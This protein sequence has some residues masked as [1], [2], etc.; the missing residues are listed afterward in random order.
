MRIF[1]VVGAL[2]VTSWVVLA[3][4]Y[5]L[6]VN[7]D[8][9][10]SA[11]AVLSDKVTLV[12]GES[13]MMLSRKEKDVGYIH[14]TRTVVD[15]GWL[16]EYEM[17]TLIELMGV[18]Q[19]IDTKMKATVDKDAVLR[20]FFGSVASVIGTFEVRGEV[21]GLTLKMTIDM[22]GT[23][24]EQTMTLKQPPRLASNALNQILAGPP[25][26]PGQVFEQEFFD[27]VSMGMNRLVYEFVEMKEVDS[28]EVKEMS[29]HFVQKVMGSEMDVFVSKTGELLIQEL[30]M[31]TVAAKLPNA[32]GRTR[33]PVIR[34]EIEKAMKDAKVSSP[35]EMMKKL[36]E[37]G[38]PAPSQ[39]NLMGSALDF[40]GSAFGANDDAQTAHR[41]TLSWLEQRDGLLLESERQRVRAGEPA[42]PP[43]FIIGGV[44][45]AADDARPWTQPAPDAAAQAALLMPGPLV[46]AD[47]AAIVALAGA[48]AVEDVGGAARSLTRQIGSK[49]KIVETPA[50]TTSASALLAAGA[51]DDEGAARVLVAAL[52][53][54]KIPA[55][56]V[57]GLLVGEDGV[58]AP[59][60]W[61]QAWDG[62]RFLELDPTQE[63]FG[64]GAK[65]VQ[66]LVLDQ[67]L[68]EAAWQALLA[69]L[70]AVKVVA[71]KAEK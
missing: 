70:R 56:L 35:E 65:H 13:W 44:A 7:R 11:A 8:G 14:E 10:A 63:D 51:A 38:G 30:P 29:Y 66:L 40:V 58:A 19:L 27:P 55:R 25:P 67:P 37:Q 36:E 22:R 53:A 60:V 23:K 5:S 2:V 4:A 18:P 34:R 52:R 59:H 16:L 15:D 42:W 64:A 71:V 45:G 26:R 54:R 47:N 41:Y 31:Y 17:F 20:Q 69:E 61:A 50:P 48:G 24:R 3:G 43:T 9:A 49:L 68:D 6:K 32:L 57:V 1:D 28:Y 46:D 39:A 62:A 33:A 12:E 21:E